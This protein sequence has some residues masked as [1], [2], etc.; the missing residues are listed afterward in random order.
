MSRHHSP[1]V[2][3]SLLQIS[4]V[5]DAIGQVQAEQVAAAN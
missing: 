5:V 1:R 2:V 4:E 3:H